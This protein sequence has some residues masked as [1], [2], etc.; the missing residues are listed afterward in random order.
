MRMVLF[1][2]LISGLFLF[3]LLG[4]VSTSNAQSSQ[5]QSKVTSEEVKKK[6]K[7]AFELGAQYSYEQK[8]EYEK[9]IN[10]RIDWL[11]ERIEELKKRAKNESA[12]AQ[13]EL[14]QTVA[15]LEDKK[16]AAKD[17]LSEI[18]S[19][20]AEAWEDVKKGTGQAFNELGDAFGKALSR[21]KD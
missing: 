14:D 17:K 5:D 2:S 18:Q 8:E 3:G 7:E 1:L 20:S 15:D 13:K 4:N 19:S 11:D 9:L 10:E 6:W 16:A 21:F 12:E